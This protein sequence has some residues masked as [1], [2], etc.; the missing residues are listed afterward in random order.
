MEQLFQQFS[1]YLRPMIQSEI[2]TA[3]SNHSVKMTAP[4]EAK[5]YTRIE[6]AKKLN[7]SLVTLNSHIQKGKI[8][9]QRIGSRVLISGDDINKCLKKIDAVGGQFA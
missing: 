7:I 1:D 3:L 2:S 5:L 9:A 6:T 8:S 4:P